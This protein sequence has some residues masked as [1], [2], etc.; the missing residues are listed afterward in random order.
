MDLWD[1]QTIIIQGC[2]IAKHVISLIP[3]KQPWRMYT[4]EYNLE[5]WLFMRLGE[6]YFGEKKRQITIMWAHTVSHDSTCMIALFIEH[7][8]PINENEKNYSHF[9]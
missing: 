3:M 9:V 8:A 1:A 6:C 4:I 2:F 5:F 7:N